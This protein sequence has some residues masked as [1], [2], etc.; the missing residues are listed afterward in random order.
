MSEQD[1]VV[2]VA[3]KRTAIGAFL[4]TI[5]PVSSID[6]GVTAVQAALADAGV[7]AGDVDDVILGQVLTAGLGQNPARQ[8]SIKSVIPNSSTAITINQV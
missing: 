4:G 3:A 2:I 5:S 8:T 1:P 7:D 6:L